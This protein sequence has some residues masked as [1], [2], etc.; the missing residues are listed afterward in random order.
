MAKKILIIDDNEQDRKIIGRVL[1]KAGFKNVSA[2]ETGEDGVKR[3]KSEKPD[4]I[5]LDTVLPGMSGFET[6]REI[7]KSLSSKQVKIIITTGAVDAVDAGKARE[8]G[9]DDYVVKTSN[10]SYLVEAIKK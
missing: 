1:A 8:A 4:L 7:R 9:A 3:A 6:C 10:F 2:A 5:V